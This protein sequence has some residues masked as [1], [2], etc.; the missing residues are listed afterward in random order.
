MH[1]RFDQ[2]DQSI[3]D[4][5]DNI[6]ESFR[7]LS[8]QMVRMH[9]AVHYDL[10]KIEHDLSV[11]W[12]EL[13]YAHEQQFLSPLR[14]TVDTIKNF[15]ARNGSAKIPSEQFKKLCI[16]L[17]D[18]ILNPP[19]AQGFNG[20]LYL[21]AETARKANHTLESANIASLLGYLAVY[22]ESNLKAA[23]P[24]KIGVEELPNV[25]LWQT[26]AKNYIQLRSK[27][28]AE[29]YDT[30]G[31]RIQAIIDQGQNMVLVV[32]KLIN[33]E[34]LF[35]QLVD[36]F[37]KE[38]AALNAC[39]DSFLADK[40]NEDHRMANKQRQ[41]AFEAIKEALPEPHPH[42]LISPSYVQRYG[43]YKA[44]YLSALQSAEG[45]KGS[46]DISLLK[47]EKTLL[48]SA[49]ELLGIPAAM[50]YPRDRQ[51]YDF[52][53]MPLLIGQ[54]RILSKMPV[55]YKLA[56]HFGLGSLQFHYKITGHKYLC[57]GYDISNTAIA[58]VRIGPMQMG[59]TFLPDSG[60]ETVYPNQSRTLEM[61]IDVGFSLEKG[62]ASPI[63]TVSC[64]GALPTQGLSG[65]D[66]TLFGAQPISALM[67]EMLWK[68]PKSE[69]SI[70]L[71]NDHSFEN[72]L[73]TAVN[74]QQQLIKGGLSA[75]LAATAAYQK[76]V[77]KV[78]SA[79]N[80]LRAYG[81]L[82]AFPKEILEKMEL[83]HSKLKILDFHI[84]GGLALSSY[85]EWPKAEDFL[86]LKKM[87][88]DQVAHHKHRENPLVGSVRHYLWRLHGCALQVK[89]AK[90]LDGLEH[91]PIDDI[92][93]ALAGNQIPPVPLDMNHVQRLQR[94]VE[95]LGLVVQVQNAKLEQQN[96]LIKQQTG[97]IEAMAQKIDMIAE[98][99]LKQQRR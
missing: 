11:L 98:F 78:K 35:H 97:K 6:R 37:E 89:E 92:Y 64:K 88:A 42:L 44:A 25:L 50:P 55:I 30:E 72:S 24:H 58:D 17:E 31:K 82:A 32:E 48:P 15:K 86:A 41:R 66:D 53:P 45:C 62:P 84:S 14:K 5:Y 63:M 80:L 60:K 20:T 52:Y 27:Q 18:W 22:A 33:N 79:F 3:K 26:A 73:K 65:G 28:P 43:Q 38:I 29:A 39:E 96:Q 74:K 1:Q 76:Q 94:Q 57:R 4:L 36:N 67:I 90:I 23:F 46:F 21:Q 51:I 81:R 93:A 99:L 85:Q 19:N 47:H 71:K 9:D 56:E 2:L 8:D 49:K 16:S 7:G 54:A 34:P 40:R 75:E 10:Q 68:D 77:E 87:I 12:S 95:D 69:V 59:S 61:Q 13:K 83:V 91:L 70:Q